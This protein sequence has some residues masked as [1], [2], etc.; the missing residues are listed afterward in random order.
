MKASV[1]NQINHRIEFIDRSILPTQNNA[2]VDVKSA[3]L[4]HRDI[5]IQRG[6]YAGL[7]FPITLG[8]DGC[9][10]YSGEEYIINPGMEWGDDENC[11]SK[12][13]HIL[14][15]PT[16]GT[17]A[18]QVCVPVI[19]LFRKP[20]H[21]S[22]IEAAAIPLAGVT[23]YRALITKAKAT[24]EKKILITGIGGGVALFALQFAKA[25]GC[26]IY[27]SSSSE[28]KIHTAKKLGAIDGVNYTEPDWDKKLIAM[29]GGG[30]DIII[31]GAAGAEFNRYFK[32]LNYGGRVVLYGGT[33]GVIDNISPQLL[34]W[35]QLQLIGSTMG[36]P[37]DFD[38]MI[39]FIAYHKIYPIIDSVYD[40]D[41]IN[42]AFDRMKSG[43]QFGKIIIAI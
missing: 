24:K 25:L 1:L 38:Y 21:L 22:V 31:D 29:S 19:N 40:L 8:S 17:F 43:T 28:L 6:Q 37:T 42:D 34:F 3:A 35:K 2:V 11:Q 41:N 10:N 26:E 7:K 9:V 23:A 30:V 20:E 33:Q 27:V 4:N 32:V 18:E 12:Q 36:T 15:L 39:N 14:G 13:F 16:D 5:W